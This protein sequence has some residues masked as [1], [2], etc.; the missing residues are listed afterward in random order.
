MTRGITK[1]YDTDPL[2]TLSSDYVLRSIVLTVFG[3][4]FVNMDWKE[5]INV[6]YFEI[7]TTLFKNPENLL[8]PAWISNSGIQFSEWDIVFLYLPRYKDEIFW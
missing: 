2:I 1:F 4:S 3:S 8:K 6:E 5:N 7:E